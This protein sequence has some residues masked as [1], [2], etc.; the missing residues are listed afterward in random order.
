MEDQLWWT[1]GAVEE[2]LHGWGHYHEEYRRVD[3]VWLIS[4]RALTRLRQV[5]TPGFFDF[6]K[7]L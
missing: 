4:Y 5:H 1:N 6:L 7:P 2:H 3:G